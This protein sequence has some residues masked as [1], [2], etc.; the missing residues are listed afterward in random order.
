[1]R[2]ARTA[3]LASLLCACAHEQGAGPPAPGAVSM[4]SNTT[5]PDQPTGWQLPVAAERS[6]RNRCIDRELAVRDLNA[7]GDPEGTTYPGGAPLGVATGAGR[8]DYVMRRR[9]DVAAACSHVVGDR[10]R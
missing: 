10:G 4:P 7:F 8:Y 9:P 6:E 2:L 1:M 5:G 3:L